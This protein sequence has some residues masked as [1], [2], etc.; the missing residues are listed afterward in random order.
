LDSLI[1]I[2]EKSIKIIALQTLL[3]L[4]EVHDHLKTSFGALS[5]TQILFDKQGNIKV[6]QSYL[7]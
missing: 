3:G 2:P 4:S 6:S 5:P 7:S 1:N